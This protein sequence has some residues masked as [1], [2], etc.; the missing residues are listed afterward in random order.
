[1]SESTSHTSITEKQ[2]LDHVYKQIMILND[3]LEDEGILLP[4]G[5][6]P[7]IFFPMM[8]GELK[9]TE[10][11]KS[12]APSDKDLDSR[13]Q[14]FLKMMSGLKL[15]S[16]DITK[17]KVYRF[18]VNLLLKARGIEA[19]LTHSVVTVLQMHGAS[20]ILTRIDEITLTQGAVILSESIIS[21]LPDELIYLV[22]HLVANCEP[23]EIW[24][25]VNNIFLKN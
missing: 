7:S 17:F 8:F 18:R 2:Y 4:K 1:M 22:Q 12:T 24:L 11:V 21:T 6:E 14:A 19:F 16:L 9:Q 25:K 20:T 13:N 3:Q 23:S 15:P 10:T 5:Y